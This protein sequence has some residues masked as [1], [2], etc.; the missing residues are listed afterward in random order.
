MNMYDHNNKTYDQNYTI[1]SMA[2]LYGAIPALGFPKHE[3]AFL[4]SAV[5]R[6]CSL[7]GQQMADLPA[8]PR[9][10]LVRLE[11]IS[12]AM[13]NMTEQS[14]ANVKSRVRKVFKKVKGQTYNPRSRFPL[15]GEWADLQTSLDTKMQRSTS[16]LFH[17]A[18]RLGVLPSQMSDAVIERFEMHLRDEAMVGNW[19]GPFRGN[20]KAWNAIASTRDLP[21]LTLPPVKRTSYWI[22][23]SEWPPSLV[24]DLNSVCEWLAKPALLEGKAAKP[25]RPATIQ[26]YRHSVTIAVSALVLSGVPICT[27]QRLADVVNPAQVNRVLTLLYKRAGEKVTP[28]MLA[29]ALRARTIARWCKALDDDLAKLDQ[30]DLAK[31][32]EIVSSI[33]DN[34]KKKRGMTAKNRALLDRLEDQ[35][36][37]DH[38]Q[39]LPLLLLEQAKKTQASHRSAALARTAMAIELLLVCSVRRANLISLELGKSIKQIGHGKDARWIIQYVDEEVKNEQSLRFHLPHPTAAMLDLYLSE[40]R[41]RL[42]SK[43]NQWLFP[44]ADGTCVNPKTMAYA[45]TAHS[46]KVLGVP[47]TPHQFRHISAELYLMENPDKLLRISDHLG[48]KDI[49]TTR[50]YYAR[51][52]QR[53][54]SRHFQEHVLKSRETARIRIKRKQR[55]RGGGGDDNGQED[56]L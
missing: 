25:L 47:I 23:Q 21:L 49:N 33:V 34:R 11:H 20:I 38:V 45:I 6:A 4:K 53:E 30:D 24:S 14:L 15:K 3:N 55:R 1:L 36:F 50:H 22:N 28:Q 8:D 39:L 43:P 19:E 51:P 41:P 9:V 18:A 52:K 27:I 12:P 5:K 35:W 40:W 44:A 46:K 7:L 48:H 16:R 29:L 56:V 17:F 32:D 54:A 26:Q 2:D 37:A 13:A 42:C 10:I 31:L